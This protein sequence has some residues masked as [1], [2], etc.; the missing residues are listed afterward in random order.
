M[1]PAHS[2]MKALS[3]A[4]ANWLRKTKQS[5]YS[6]KTALAKAPIIRSRERKALRSTGER[7]CSL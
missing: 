7:Y 5:R 2:E 1:K 6:H 3:Y 4:Q